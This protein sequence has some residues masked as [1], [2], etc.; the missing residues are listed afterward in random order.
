MPRPQT[1]TDDEL[2]RR[3]VKGETQSEIARC[4]NMTRQ[5]VSQRARQIIE[6]EKFKASVNPRTAIISVWDARAAAQDNFHRLLAMLDDK[7][8]ST[9]DRIRLAREIRQQ[10]AFSF[11]AIEPLCVVEGARQFVEGALAAFEEEGPEFHERILAHIKKHESR[12]DPE[13]HDAKEAE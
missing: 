2:I 4:F 6:R 9:L 10:I 11:H 5:A 8:L 3:I 1:I 7:G 12:K 13:S